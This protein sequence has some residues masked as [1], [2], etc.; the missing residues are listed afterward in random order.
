MEELHNNVGSLD[1]VASRMKRNINS[2]KNDN[3]KMAMVVIIYQ[4]NDLLS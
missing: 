4:H 1:D 2:E 3:G